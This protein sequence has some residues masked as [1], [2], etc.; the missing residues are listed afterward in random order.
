[1]RGCIVA[2][3]GKKLCISDLANIEGRVLTCLAGETWKI[4]AFRAF[5]EGTGHDLYKI[6]A[7]RILNKDPAEVTKDERQVTGKVPELAL[8][9]QGAV[10]AFNTMAAIYG[11]NLPEVEVIEIVRSWRASH[12]K[13]VAL[14]YGME[15]ACI[16]ATND[17]GSQHT[18]GVIKV[19]LDGDWMR[20][21]L[22][23][24]R[25]LTYCQP[26]VTYETVT[27]K[28]GSTWQSAKLSI[29]GN[30][31]ITRQWC[32]IPTYGGMIV[33]NIVQAT[34]RD[35]LFAAMR[36]AEAAGYAIVLRV[37]DEL[38]TEVPDTD[39]FTHEGLSEIMSRELSWTKGW[40]LAAAGFET[41]RY[42][43]E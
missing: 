42:R 43:K 13:T 6:G 21:R 22:P 15:K 40:P 36:P 31:P 29:M 26:R 30:H 34:A 28:D 16:A 41:R 10:G 9:F 33:E 2:P 23:S 18:V 17:P 8:G 12:P 11:V 24:G 1:V 19:R 25:C 32:R 37:H 3:P 14:W 27:R 4:E 20:I 35:V 7:G 5:D 39:E 38:I